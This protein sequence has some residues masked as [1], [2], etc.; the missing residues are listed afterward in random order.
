MRAVLGLWMLAFALWLGGAAGVGASPGQTHIISVEGAAL[1]A[2]PE[3]GAEL[4]R[5][6]DNASRVKELRRQGPWIKVLVFG[7]I[8]LEGWIHEASLQPE[9]G[10]ET[11]G[12]SVE[13]G[14]PPEAQEQRPRTRQPRFTLEVSGRQQPFRAGCTIFDARGES[15]RWRYEGRSP[16]RL[17]L[18]GAALRCRVDR[19]SQHAGLLT[20]AL[21][22]RG[23]P[24]PLAQN[25]TQSTF[26]C[27]RLR[28][29]GPW[30]RAYARRCSRIAIFPNRQTTGAP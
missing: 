10:R 15:R 27:V 16:A 8:G 24:L 12:A 5:T 30:G 19:L 29:D 17:R 7:A 23:T 1:R 20:V 14:D 21:H 28:S 9:T 18:D 26:G 13:E 2:A 3:S 22:E 25:R 4:V 6:L 11:G